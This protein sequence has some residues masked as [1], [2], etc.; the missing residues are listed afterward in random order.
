M[1]LWFEIA[2]LIL[3]TWMG[4]S[5]YLIYAHLNGM[6]GVLLQILERLE[7]AIRGRQ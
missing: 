6:R 5:L 3:L 4:S 2:L 7:S 1:P